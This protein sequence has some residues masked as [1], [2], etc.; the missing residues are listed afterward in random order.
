MSELPR[1]Q[2]P[3]ILD[4]P[5]SWGPPDS[6]STA[7]FNDIPYAP[8]SKFDKIG[9]AADWAADQPRDGQD[10]RGRQRARQTRDQNF[11]AYGSNAS[12]AF[13]YQQA[14]EDASF[15]LVDNR[16]AAAKKASLYKATGQKQKFTRGADKTGRRGMQRLGGNFVP[17]KGGNRFNQGQGGNFRKRFGYND[18]KRMQGT[19]FAS[20][21]VAKD[22][23]LDQDLDFVRLN[24][25]SFE[26]PNSKD[27]G[28]YGSV[29]TF[30]SRFE[31][32]VSM[33]NPV[34]LTKKS[35]IRYD[36]TASEDPIF[37]QLANENKATVFVTDVVLSALMASTR[38]VYPWEIII[39]RV[40]D[41]LFLDKRSG[42]S[43]DFFTVNENAAEPPLESAEKDN[44]INSASFLAVEAVEINSR[45]LT[46]VV[47][48]NERISCENPNP[49][50]E[51]ETETDGAEDNGCYK[52]RLFNMNAR[53]SEDQQMDVDEET[54]ENCIMAVRTQMDAVLDGNIEKPVMVRALNQ[55]DIRAVG[56]GGALDW[57]TKLDSQ[58]GAVVAT[59]LKNNAAKLGKWAFQ[60]TLADIN[61]LKIGFVTRENIK[62]S[63][64][65]NLLGVANFKPTE[66]IR[67]MGYNINKS[68]GIV[69]AM[70]DLCMK[71]D[72]GKYILVRDP[73]KPVIKLYSI[74]ST[75]V[76]NEDD[77]ENEE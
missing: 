69:K 41:K 22:W 30:N 61:S 12:S 53:V 67:Q 3:K 29:P 17:N 34:V 32:T 54:D 59:E 73:S 11:Q 66:L 52:Y 28:T 62:N 45:I 27:F 47:N 14:E 60:A 50:N 56:A 76:F 55:F 7:D 63:Q 42:G 40:G 18:Y 6:L 64:N 39:N 44:N 48:P 43:L 51:A 4:Q 24:K 1:F 37:N 19:R 58:R 57:N 75:T 33:K 49:F 20:I 65:H 31:R 70:I 2:L 5:T 9:K 35:S 71:L 77:G 8:F 26:V 38:S 10:Q 25:L 21:E 72:E 23:V 74:P 16:S 68:W 15:S 46:Q 36:V 13:A